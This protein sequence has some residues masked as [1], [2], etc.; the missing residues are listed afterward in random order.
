[1]LPIEDRG[2]SF[3]MERLGEAQWVLGA[4]SSELDE[5]SDALGVGRVRS[6]ARSLQIATGPAFAIWRQ[7]C[8]TRE[9]FD[10]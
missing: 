1:M 3:E 5:L 6:C 7:L 2:E 9:K 8:C 10:L 4:T